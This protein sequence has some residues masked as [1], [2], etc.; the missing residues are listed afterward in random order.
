MNNEKKTTSSDRNHT[1]RKELLAELGNLRGQFR[2]IV[3]RYQSDLEAE[4]V[5]CIN[6]LSASEAGQESQLPLNNKRL[7]ELVDLIN[8]LKI[9]PH[10][11]RLKDINR[12]DKVVDKI[13]TT[14]GKE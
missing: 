13:S 10:K 6:L 4:L 7:A 14:L 8:D 12:I 3:G 1:Q 2:D 9:K 11:G 5:K